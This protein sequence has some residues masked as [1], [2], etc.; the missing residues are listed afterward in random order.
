MLTGIETG[1]VIKSLLG[2]AEGLMTSLN[3]FARTSGKIEQ[4]CSS[5]SFMKLG[6]KEHWLT[7]SWMLALL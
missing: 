7:H 6:R 5:N 4:Q 2:K 3:I 1:I